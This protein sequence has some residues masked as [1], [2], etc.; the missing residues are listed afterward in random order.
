MTTD[1]NKRPLIEFKNITVLKNVN[2]VVLDS[3]TITIN[4]GENVA[5]L[6]P[7]G[8]GKSSLIKTITRQHYPSYKE[9]EYSARIWGQDEWNI[10]DLR[11]TLGI[12]SS[13]LQHECDRDVM[14]FETILSGFF[15]SIGIYKEPVTP[16]MEKKVKEVM[17]F[18]EIAHLKD[19]DM[20]EMSSGEA[21]RFLIGR[22]LVHE[23]KALI[24]DEPMNNLD[25][26]ALFKFTD[27]LSK[28]AKSGISVILVTQ[29]IEDIIPEITR[30]VFMK[31]GKIAIDG[32]KQDI[33]T[34]E[35]ISELYNT[36]IKLEARDGFYYA[37]R[38]NPLR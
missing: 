8:A 17:D 28:L 1:T 18:L 3:I 14:G 7:N 2:R 5:I 32:A 31:N 23:P 6:G 16:E 27:I 34:S 22:A 33:L 37:F 25:P 36:P 35:K 11:S 15:S 26:H 30:V 10:F 21:R 38:A 13:D 20:D 29:N 12:V 9:E 24:L 4:Q 19:K